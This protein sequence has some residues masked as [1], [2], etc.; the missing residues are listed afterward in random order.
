MLKK[1]LVSLLALACIAAP[2]ATQAHEHGEAGIA[3][4]FIKEIQ[5]SEAIYASDRELTRLFQTVQFS[6]TQLASSNATGLT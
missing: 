3:R 5:A 6:T 4:A 2:L 1:H